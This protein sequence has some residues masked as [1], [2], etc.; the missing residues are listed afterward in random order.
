MFRVPENHLSVLVYPRGLLTMNLVEG[1]KSSPERNGCITRIRSYKPLCFGSVQ[2]LLYAFSIYFD[3][4]LVVFY[5]APSL[6]SVVQLISTEQNIQSLV[7][8]LYVDILV[9][10]GSREIRCR[11]N[12]ILNDTKM[13]HFYCDLNVVCTL[14]RRMH[15]TCVV[16]FISYS[17]SFVNNAQGK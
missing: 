10:H 9:R 1:C 14:T 5:A 15:I 16:P 3:F 11:F 17:T 13:W 8:F 6:G 4:G 2:R 7:V 12:I